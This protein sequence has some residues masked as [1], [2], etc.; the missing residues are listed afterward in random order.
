MNISGSFPVFS[1]ENI[2]E[3]AESVKSMLRSGRLTDGPYIQE[4]ERRF[5]E[6]TGTNHALAVS[7][8]TAALT[9][10]LHH[11]K[12]EGREVVV[13]TNT[14]VSSSRHKICT[15]NKLKILWELKYYCLYF[16]SRVYLEFITVV[17]CISLE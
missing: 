4:F 9:V 10:A 6:Y 17:K 11:F 16:T 15:T 14:F 13:P 1:E 5:A 3:I 12:L 2:N 8:G 7:S